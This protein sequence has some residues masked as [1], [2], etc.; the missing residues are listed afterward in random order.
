LQLELPHDMMRLPTTS[1]FNLPN[2]SKL[3]QKL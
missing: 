1:I 3:P 2:P